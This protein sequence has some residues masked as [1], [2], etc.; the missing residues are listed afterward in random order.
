MEF[1]SPE[2]LDQI[3]SS[4]R[5]RRIY[6]R[7]VFTRSRSDGDVEY[8]RSHGWVSPRRTVSASS[9]MVWDLR[10]TDEQMLAGLSANWR[11]NLNRALRRNLRIVRW[12]NPSPTVLGHL[13]E[14]MATHKGVDR[15]FDTSALTALLRSLEGQTVIYGCE[16][17]AGVPLA[18]RGCALQHQAAWDLL[19]ATSP[20]GRR[21]Y[22][23]YA[24]FWTLIRHCR[25]G[26]VK[27]YDLSGVDPTG[28]PGVY[29]FKRGTGAREQEYLGEWE[30]TTSALLA[31]AVNVGVR[32]RSGSAMV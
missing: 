19:A 8:L 21:C 18:V 31:R 7:V 30:W 9:T 17:D 28:A 29:D 32:F 3:G 15:Y 13:F 1:W 14:V 2:L 20:E 4:T 22:A 12:T 26:G 5:A 6:C 27:Q 16:N 11:H 23:S 10:P 24:V 25:A